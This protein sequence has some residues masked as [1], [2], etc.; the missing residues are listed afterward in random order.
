MPLYLFLPTPENLPLIRE[1]PPKERIPCLAHASEFLQAEQWLQE[2][3]HLIQDAPD[4]AGAH[5]IRGR[6]LHHLGRQ[7]EA[8]TAFREAL[9]LDPHSDSL[10]LETCDLLQGL[11]RQAEV[12]ELIQVARGLI[13]RSVALLVR[14]FEVI[15][16]AEGEDGGLAFLA[17]ALEEWRK[18]PEALVGLLGTL[19]N[20][21]LRRKDTREVPG[22]GSDPIRLAHCVIPEFD[23]LAPVDPKSLL[24]RGEL[25]ARFGDGNRATELLGLAGTTSPGNLEVLAAA[26]RQL[27]LVDIPLARA[28]YESAIA[29]RDPHPVRLGMVLERLGRREQAR[30]AYELA[31]D[32]QEFEAAPA[33]RRLRLGDTRILTKPTREQWDQMASGC[34]SSREDLDHINRH[35]FAGMTVPD[36]GTLLGFLRGA[37]SI[38]PWLVEE[39][40]EIIGFIT[41][42]ESIPGHRDAFGLVIGR[43]HSG[44]GSGFRA[45]RDLVQRRDELGIRA[46]NGYCNRNNWPIISAML[47]CGFRNVPGFRDRRDR[48]AVQY[49][50]HPGSQAIWD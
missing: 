10:A 24:L 41:H 47:A 18:E 39:A 3:D 13:P 12:S 20:R 37:P 21:A 11:G 2:A 38:R 44:K 46:L 40:G 26:A 4:L 19:A 28:M 9:R 14:H 34:L 50:L 22:P 25:H 45:L 33:L 27:E 7:E 23:R 17:R 48:D 8:I 42:G 29:V 6:A 5:A 31:I 49:T 30:Q 32:L 16:A 43:R 36:A 1:M 35:P 15:S